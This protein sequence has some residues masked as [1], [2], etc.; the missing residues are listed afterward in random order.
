MKTFIVFLF[1][2]IALINPAFSQV[3]DKS[4]DCS[5]VILKIENDTV[6]AYSDRWCCFENDSTIL[7]HN[8]HWKIMSRHDS[9]TPV[10]FA[11][12]RDNIFVNYSICIGYKGG[13]TLTRYNALGIADSTV[14]IDNNYEN[15]VVNDIWGAYWSPRQENTTIQI[16][17][18]NRK[19]RRIIVGENYELK[20]ILDFDEAGNLV[21]EQFFQIVKIEKKKLKKK[22]E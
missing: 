2:I 21:K 4:S 18:K 3:L 19:L 7:T 22:R 13:Y 20:Y 5:I 1:A 15:S 9:I 10:F 14:I 8:G 16:Y 17:D 11:E 12:I 6:F